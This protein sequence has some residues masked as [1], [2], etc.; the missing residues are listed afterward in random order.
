MGSHQFWGKSRSDDNAMVRAYTSNG[1]TWWWCRRQWGGELVAYVLLHVLEDSG[2]GK[3]TYKGGSR[4]CTLRE[5]RRACWPGRMVKETVAGDLPEQNIWY[6]LKYNRKMLMP[7]E[8]DMDARIRLKGNDD[9]DIYIWVAMRVQGGVYRRLL[10]HK[11][12]KKMNNNRQEIDK[13]KNGV[14][15]SIEKKLFD[16]FKKMGCIAVVESTTSW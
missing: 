16:M 10:Q 2:D 13:Q 14:G 3:V 4:K 12:G 9:Y 15:K 5:R 7:V 6:N 11:L 1:C 8:G